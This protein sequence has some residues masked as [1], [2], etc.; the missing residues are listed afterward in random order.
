MMIIKKVSKEG[1]RTR[2]RYKQFSRIIK[3]I[4]HLHFFS[5]LFL[6]IQKLQAN[7]SIH[8]FY[9]QIK[10]GY[11]HFFKNVFPSSKAVES[12]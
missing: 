3:I 2:R 5:D 12:I 6:K 1:I 7:K 11:K 10:H 4:T 9:C 8:S